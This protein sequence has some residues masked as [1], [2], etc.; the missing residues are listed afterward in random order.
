MFSRGAFVDGPALGQVSFPE[1]L[2][3]VRAA[4]RYALRRP[5][6]LLI[7]H[8]GP[9]PHTLMAPALPGRRPDDRHAR[10][11]GT[12]RRNRM[13]R[14]A[15]AYRGADADPAGPAYGTICGRDATF[16]T[17]IA[18]DWALS[19]HRLI[20]AGTLTIQLVTQQEL[21]VEVVHIQVRV[22]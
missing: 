4:V 19:G 12:Q 11:P 6:V 10:H 8:D 14:A 13:G 22:E 17:F 21:V 20:S 2:D 9:H 15:R 16:K 7:D 3:S 1:C 5:L 18:L